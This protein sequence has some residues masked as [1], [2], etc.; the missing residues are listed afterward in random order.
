MSTRLQESASTVLDVNGAGMVAVGPAMQP[1]PAHW[2]IDGAVIQTS[3]PGLAPVPQCQ[4][5]LNSISPGSS[6]GLTY[7][8][9]FK[10]AGGSMILNLGDTLYAV[11]TA[12]G[13]GDTATLTVTGTKG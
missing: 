2:S 1:G 4:L 6:L 3:R 10:A 13:S 12:G 5:Y 7:D 8:G 9:S 11:W